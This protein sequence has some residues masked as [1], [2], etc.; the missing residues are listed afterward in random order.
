MTNIYTKDFLSIYFSQYVLKLGFPRE[1]Y[2]TR[3]LFA[4][5]GKKNWDCCGE[6]HRTENRVKFSLYV[7]KDDGNVQINKG[8]MLCRAVVTTE[9]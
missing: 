7:S 3:S 9:G 4:G 2:K 5:V 1:F 6:P 8:S